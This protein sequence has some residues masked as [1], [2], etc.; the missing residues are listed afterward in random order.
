MKKEVKKFVVYYNERQQ[1]IGMR[2]H[3][4]DWEEGDTITTDGV[5][6]T[7]FGIFEGTKKNLSLAH[8]MFDTLRKYLPKKK[9][10]R[11]RDEGF[12][13]TGDQIEDM[14]N[15]LVH[16]HMELVDV[17]KKIWKNFDAQLDFVDSVFEKMNK[18]GGKS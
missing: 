14:L 10:V 2:E 4:F 13:K 1:L 8:R 12:V 16:S 9:M 6:T 17:H 3:H 7:I 18:K 5:S 15:A 11:V